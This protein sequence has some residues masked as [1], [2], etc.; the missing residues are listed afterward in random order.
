MTDYTDTHIIATGPHGYGGAVQS[1]CRAL[2]HLNLAGIKTTYV[3]LD[4]PVPLQKNPDWAIEHVP[5]SL[6][7]GGAIGFHTAPVVDKH[8]LVPEV[9]AEKMALCARESEHQRIV[10]WGTY[11]FPYVRAVTMA[12]DV[13]RDDPRDIQ[14]WFSPTGS[15][16][17]HIAPNIHEVT[18]RLLQNSDADAIIVPSQGFAKEI[19]DNLR[20]ERQQTVIHPMIEADRFVMPTPEKRKAIR[21]ELGFDDDD[22]VMTTH[23]NFRRIKR[24][25]DV[26]RIAEQV[27]AQLERPAHIIMMGTERPEL[28]AFAETTLKHTQVHW[29]GVVTDVE[30]YLGA[31]DV[32]INCCA[33]DSFN[34][35]L[36][37]AMACGVPVVSTDLVGV[38]THIKAANAGYLFP[39][40]P[41]AHYDEAAYTGN[42]YTDAVAYICKLADNEIERRAIGKRGSV[43]THTHLRPEDLLGG[44]LKL[45][46]T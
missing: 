41:D 18:R 22:F 5:V 30:R 42:R 15:D 10:L 4:K 7:E 43:Y 6:V 27:G 32:E 38:S 36:A 16:V 2:Q 40:E 34:L 39:Y 35:S 31:S 24:P 12:Y 11:L 21:T 26:L 25:K 9:I 8:I 13:L 17:H 28:H 20:V 29:M 33:H 14:L 19:R 44:Y 46:D 1:L 3:A 23:S 45:L 37:E